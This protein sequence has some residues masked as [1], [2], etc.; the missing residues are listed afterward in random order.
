M[1]PPKLERRELE[2]LLDV[3]RRLVS[4]RELDVVLH[5]MLE[6]ARDLTG[7]R[8]AAL[9]VLDDAREGLDRFLTIG[10]DE[11]TRQAIGSPPRGRGILGE[12]IREPKPLRLAQLGSHPR[13]YGFPPN[14]PPMTTFLGVP[15]IVRGEAFGNLYLTEKEHGEEFTEEDEQV[16]VVLADYAATAIDNARLYERLERRHEELERAV[17]GLRA[18]VELARVVDVE[19][20]P[21]RTLELIAKRG[22]ALVDARALL[23]LMPEDEQLVVVEAAGVG[24]GSLR[25]SS[26][27][28]ADS[29]PGEV[30]RDGRTERLA[31]VASP[32]R[33]GLG[34]LADGFTSG[35]LAPL[36]FHGRP[37]GVLLAL[38]RLDDGET[39]DPD[40][41]LLLGSFAA[42]AGSALARAQMV[43]TEK[44]HLALESA[45]SERRRWAR[46]LHD[47]TLQELVALK[48]MLEA[49]AQAA[50]H[51][52]ASVTIAG[53]LDRVARG[54]EDLQGLIAELRPAALDQLGLGPALESLVERVAAQS[55]LDL[56]ARIQLAY[57]AGR[58]STRLDPDLEG[59]VYRLVQEALNNVVKHAGARRVTVDVTENASRVRVA[60]RDDGRGFDPATPVRGFGLVGMRE[61]MATVAG[62]VE[63][64]SEPGAGTLVRAEMPVHRVTADVP[65]EVIEV[66]RAG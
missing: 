36:I 19:T 59:A 40:D 52:D 27:P 60:V 15:I 41:E 17:S 62:T 58:A 14:H 43:E 64:R 3:G 57:D 38:D 16:L 30:L 54:I 42:S 10:V 49:A 50:S 65:G 6:A 9:G 29:L 34:A 31:D 18:H 53:A 33:L 21:A 51:E 47:E 12:L 22:R 35:L 63:V 5:H 39:F 56:E 23:V 1:S 28:I 11:R 25:S 45:E 37:Q 4:E 20:D 13:S 66:G 61:R 44:L 48:M 7:A 2:R 55:S 32:V 46:E 8:Y 24:A 26:I